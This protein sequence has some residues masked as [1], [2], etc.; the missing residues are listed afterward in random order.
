MDY[1]FV[2]YN[3][4]IIYPLISL[5]VGIIPLFL[6][7]VRLSI[8][9]LGLLAYFIAI[10]AKIVVQ[11]FTA[12]LILSYPPFIIGVYYGAQTLLF[13]VGFAFLFVSLYK[14]VTISDAMGYGISLAFAENAVLL[15]AISLLSGVITLL[16]FPM[17]PHSLQV[18]ISEEVNIPITYDIYHFMDRVSSLLAHTAWG[19]ASVLYFVEKKKEYFLIGLVGFVDDFLASYFNLGL[20]SYFEA[21]VMVLGISLIGFLLMYLILKRL[22]G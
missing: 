14:K 13:E 19:I 10:T 8:L 6:V 17:L 9:G 18:T 21:S 3:A 22:K 20:I 11:F 1:P 12:K 15:G 2:Y 4:L 5:I 7:R 16:I